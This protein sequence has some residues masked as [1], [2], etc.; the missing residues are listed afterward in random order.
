ME[1]EPPRDVTKLGEMS[2][3][4]PLWVV[5]AARWPLFPVLARLGTL[6]NALGEGEGGGG[7]GI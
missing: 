5:E 2:D 1:M 4:A 7:Y 6:L 3:V